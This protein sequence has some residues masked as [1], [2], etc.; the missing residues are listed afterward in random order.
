MA[1]SSALSAQRQLAVGVIGLGFGERVHIPAF[2]ADAR[3]AVASVCAGRLERA[4][5]AASRLGIPKAVERWEELVADPA[6]DVVAIATP[7]VLQ[8]EIAIAAF[9]HGKHV[10]CEKPLAINAD[11]AKRMLEAA[12]RAGTVHAV[13]FE[14]PLIP[15]WEQAKAILDRGGI[16]RV[17]H[18]AVSWQVQTR[19]SR[20]GMDS[21]KTRPEEGGGV[22]AAFGSH[23]FHY[24]EWLLGPIRRLSARLRGTPGQHSGAGAETGMIVSLELRSGALVSVSISTDTPWGRGH[25]IEL[26]GEAGSL[27]LENLSSDYVRGFS[28][29]HESPQAERGSQ[30]WREAPGEARA[31]DGRVEAVARL[32]HRFLDRICGGPAGHPNL[33]D[34]YRVQCLIDAAR[35]SHASSSWTDVSLD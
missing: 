22:L 12:R 35:A 5:A 11:E 27:R 17:R 21:W 24:I 19:A 18:A 14:F 25:R 30:E 10:F 29:R 31:E 23:V 7:P 15:S 20:M 34:G 32:T 28:L 4:A 3:C 1:G 16:G 33:E 26:Y 6:I 8:P 9:R 13:D 2:R